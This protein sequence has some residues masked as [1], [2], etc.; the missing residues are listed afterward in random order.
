MVGREQLQVVDRVRHRGL[1]YSVFVRVLSLVG[2]EQH[3][4]VDRVSHQGLKYLVFIMVLSM[5]GRQ[6]GLFVDR[7]APRVSKFGISHGK[8]IKNGPNL[9]Y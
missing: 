1:K 7:G 9:W 8:C 4:V 6:R 5:V 3:Q 2:R